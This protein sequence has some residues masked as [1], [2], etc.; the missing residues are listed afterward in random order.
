MT[1]LTGT[2]QQNTGHFRSIIVL[3]NGIVAW[4]YSPQLVHFAFK[5]WAIKITAVPGKAEYPHTYKRRSKQQQKGSKISEWKTK[6]ERPLGRPV[7]GCK[8]VLVRSHGPIRF[9]FATTEEGFCPQISLSTSSS[10]IQPPLPCKTHGLEI[11][12]LRN[13]KFQNC[14]YPLFF[15][16]PSPNQVL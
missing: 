7:I 16:K 13:S 1:H 14:F 15:S 4:R 8:S 10:A 5:A 6:K 11:K 9:R 3:K 12:L 2:K